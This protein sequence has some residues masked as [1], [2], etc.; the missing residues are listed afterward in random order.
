MGKKYILD[1]SAIISGKD[2]PSDIETII[3]ESVLNE[4]LDYEKYQILIGRSIVLK[5]SEDFIKMAK[6]AAS[7]TGDIYKLSNVDIDVI[8]LTLEYGGIAITD[9]YAIQNVLSHLSADF[10]GLN[11][12]GIKERYTW[13]YRCKGCRRY[14]KEYHKSCPYCG[15]EL[16]LVRKKI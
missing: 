16:K 14:F 6:K 12:K 11:E 2:L 13:I 3:P 9:D 1:T 8:A 4:I 10:V 7:E 5:P 15:S